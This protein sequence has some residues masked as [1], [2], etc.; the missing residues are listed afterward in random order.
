MDIGG[1]RRLDI[2]LDAFAESCMIRDHGGHSDV[3][4]KREDRPNSLLEPM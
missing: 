2:S 4:S 1:R 3:N